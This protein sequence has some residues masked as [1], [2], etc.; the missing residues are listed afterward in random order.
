MF[1]HQD[2]SILG[3]LPIAKVT[4]K[5]SLRFTMKKLIKLNIL[6]SK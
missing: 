4:E 5:M 2:K 6:N 1:D 3:P